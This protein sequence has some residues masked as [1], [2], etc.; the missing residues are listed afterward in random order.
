MAPSGYR[1]MKVLRTLYLMNTKTNTGQWKYTNNRCNDC[2]IYG[3]IEEKCWK[4]HLELNLK[5]H[6][7][8]GKK[9]TF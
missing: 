7:K 5:N 3:H 1:D 9:G 8:D 6:K 2:N 4:L